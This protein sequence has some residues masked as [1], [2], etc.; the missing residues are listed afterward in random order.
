M[1]L[2]SNKRKN[3][4]TQKKLRNDESKNIN[5]NKNFYDLQEEYIAYAKKKEKLSKR[6]DQIEE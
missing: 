5:Q 1:S 4:L 3:I 6:L 2:L